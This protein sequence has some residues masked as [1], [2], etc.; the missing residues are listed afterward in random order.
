MFP[1]SVSKLMRYSN[2]DP[3]AYSQERQQ[4]DTQSSSTR[5]LVRGEDTQIGR[6]RLE[7]HTMQNLGRSIPGER[8]QELAEKVGRRSGTSNRYWSFE[9]QLIGS[10][11]YLCRQRRKPP[12]ILDQIKLIIWK[13]S[14]TQTSRTSGIYSI[15][16]RDWYSTIKPKFW[17]WQR[18]LGQLHQGRDLHLRTT[19]W[20]RARLL[21]FRLVLV[22]DAG[23]FRSESKTEKSS[24]RISTV[25]FL[26]RTNFFR[27][28]G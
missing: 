11:D 28:D 19:K 16:R 1:L 12:F 25:Q 5:K 23:A 7:F 6:T 4:D 8:L 20:S 24:W 10:G 15:S 14:G 3:T 27:I 21:G 2:H 26:Q 9:D 13:F 22:E 17:M 18:L